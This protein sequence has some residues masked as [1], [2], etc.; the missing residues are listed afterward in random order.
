MNNPVEKGVTFMSQWGHRD[1]PLKL[2]ILVIG[3]VAKHIYFS[4]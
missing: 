1:L 2:E 3:T 4:K